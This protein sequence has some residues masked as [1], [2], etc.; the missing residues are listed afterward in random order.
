MIAWFT[1]F[2]RWP[3]KV[4]VPFSFDL[5][6]P[7]SRVYKTTDGGDT[8]EMLT[9]GLP[10]GML[11]RIGIA[12]Y[13]RDPNI[14]YLSIE[15]ANKLGM[16]DEERLQELLGHQ[17]SRGMIALYQSVPLQRVPVRAHLPSGPVDRR[18]EGHS[19]RRSGAQV[20]LER[21]HP[22]QLP[23]LRRHLPRR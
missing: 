10:Q 21:S 6:G 23:R 12:G 16:S 8:W 11:G 13:L 3:Y 7:G 14:V 22:H 4:R 19:L 1:D 2:H 9:N 17:P 18:A 5:G 15:N 20:E